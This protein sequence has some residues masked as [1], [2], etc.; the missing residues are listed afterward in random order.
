ML[1]VVGVFAAACGR[2]SGSAR[3]TGG[4]QTENGIP[5]GQFP[6]QYL[7]GQ[8]PRAPVTGAPGVVQMISTSAVANGSLQRGDTLLPDGRVADDYVI[9]LI[10]GVPVTI[11]ARG[12]PS[13][14]SPGS[15]LDMYVIL[16]QSGSEVTHDDDSASNGTALNS[17]IVYTPVV[18]GTFVIRVTTYGSR[19]SEGSYTLQ[20]YPGALYTQM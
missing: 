5:R 10:A 2:R 8:T 15:S 19:L 7:P 12:G 6:A 18:T 14:T 3:S 20:T 13:I 11:V 9:Q 1:T 4:A 17:R 16:L